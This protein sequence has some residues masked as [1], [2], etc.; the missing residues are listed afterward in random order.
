MRLIVFMAVLVAFPYQSHASCG[1]FLRRAVRVVQAFAG[2]PL[3]EEDLPIDRQLIA[4][5]FPADRDLAFAWVDREGLSKNSRL[6]GT[7]YW[8]PSYDI[9]DFVLTVPGWRAMMNRELRP[10]VALDYLLTATRTASVNQGLIAQSGLRASHLE[11]WERLFPQ[12]PI[13]SDIRAL[14]VDRTA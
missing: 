3:M 7:G 8:G 11:R 6:P 14:L 1:E 5:D 9:I 2:R 12:R 4:I 13:P 10:L